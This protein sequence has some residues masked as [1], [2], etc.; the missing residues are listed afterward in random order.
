MTGKQ[1]TPKSESKGST[2]TEKKIDS[3]Q[4][5]GT[6]AKKQQSRPRG[7]TF[8]MHSKNLTQGRLPK[9]R[10]CMCKIKRES[11]RVIYKF[12]AHRSFEHP[13][14]HFFCVNAD[15]LQKALGQ[16]SDDL[17]KFMNKRW[18][19]PIMKEIVK[20]MRNE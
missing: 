9:C 7:F 14:V 2:P 5:S 1:K 6:S 15:C 20:Q 18:G 8:E 10:G 13:E 17:Q 4:E 3:S 11:P 19:E 12:F 16:G